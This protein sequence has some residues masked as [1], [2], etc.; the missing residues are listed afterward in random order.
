[1]LSKVGCS[2]SLLFPSVLDAERILSG[3]TQELKEAEEGGAKNVDDEDDS[4]ISRS[5]S[6]NDKYEEVIKSTDL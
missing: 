4:G 1:M 3:T 2:S 5:E 6:P